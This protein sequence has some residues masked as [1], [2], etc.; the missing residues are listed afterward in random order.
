ML[1]SLPLRADW[2]QALLRERWPDGVPF[3]YRK[4]AEEYSAQYEELLAEAIEWR[5][6]RS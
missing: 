1:V 5:R 4:K 6:D 2:E 3:E